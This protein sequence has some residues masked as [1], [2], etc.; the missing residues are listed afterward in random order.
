[1]TRLMAAMM[2]LA[3]AAAPALAQERRCGWLQNPGPANWYLEDRDG[4]WVLWTQGRAMPPGMLPV[5]GMTGQD[6][7][8]PLGNYGYGC[9]CLTIVADPATGIVTRIDEARQ[10]PIARCEADRALPAPR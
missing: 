3:L 6:W 9:A 10:W 7:V 5:T 8:R 4:Q 2:I 1:M